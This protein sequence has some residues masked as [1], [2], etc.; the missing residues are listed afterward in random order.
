MPLA[1]GARLGPYEILSS[2]GAGGMGEVYR[3]REPG[4]VPGGATAA[5]LAARLSKRGADAVHLPTYAEIK[6]H[7]QNL[8]RPGDVLVTLGAGDI[9]TI[10]HGIGQG[11]REIRKAG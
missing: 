5:E 1:S 3:A 2:L 10:A 4:V 8:L 6:R 9:G 11:I 7:V